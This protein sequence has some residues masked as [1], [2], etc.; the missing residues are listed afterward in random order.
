MSEAV[1]Q[2]DGDDADLDFAAPDDADVSIVTQGDPIRSLACVVSGIVEEAK[3][4]FDADGL[5]ITAV[6][7]TNVA[8][9][10][11]EVPAEAWTGYECNGE[12]V[13]G[14]PLDRFKRAL[15]FA[16]KRSGD[17]DPVR[18]DLFESGTRAR[19]RVAVLRPDEGVRRVSE[20]YTIDPDSVREEPDVPDLTLGNHAQVDIDPFRDVVESIQY[21]YGYLSRAGNTLLFGTQPTRNYKLDDDTDMVEIVEFTAS[22]WSDDDAGEDESSLFSLDYLSDIMQAIDTGKA[23]HLTI[24]FG[25]E[26][27]AMFRSEWTDWGITADFVLAPRMESDGQ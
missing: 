9:T 20:F 7:P 5:S 10:D 15:S 24:D 17:G 13:V 26:L 6:N 22:A 12:I 27:P 3:L 4:R 1:P 14:M 11:V 19:C 2:L 25:D 21:D 18:I 23:D 16:R 8:M